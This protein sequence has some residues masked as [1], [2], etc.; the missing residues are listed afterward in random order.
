MRVT[1]I[2]HLSVTEEEG[3]AP[4]ILYLGYALLLSPAEAEI[5]LTVL[6]AEGGEAPSAFAL[7]SLIGSEDPEE[8]S[9]LVNRI[10]RKARAIGG[11]KL[12]VGVSHKGY[13]V[14]PYM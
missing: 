11:R 13:R 4:R 5:L 10:N 3:T 12:I 9:V 1:A 6:K 14:D 2:G 8:V 7:A